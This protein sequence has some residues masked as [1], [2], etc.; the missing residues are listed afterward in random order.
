M[1]VLSTLSLVL[2]FS[3]LHAQTV[4]PDFTFIEG[5]IIG[6]ESIN[7]LRC[8]NVA[9]DCGPFVATEIYRSSLDLATG[10]LRP[11]ALLDRVTD[12]AATTYED[13]TDG[14][15]YFYFLRYD[16]DC[17][18]AMGPS[19]DTLRSGPLQPVDI[20][21]FSVEDG[22]LRIAYTAS[23]PQTTNYVISLTMGGTNEVIGTTGNELSYLIPFDVLAGLGVDPMGDVSGLFIV[24][25]TDEVC[26]NTSPQSQPRRPG[27]VLASGGEGCTNAISYDLSQSRVGELDAID[28]AGVELFISANGGPF[29]GQGVQPATSTELT[30]DG[31]NDGDEI[32]QYVEY[33]VAGTDERFRVIVLPGTQTIDI[34]QPV[35]DFAVFGVSELPNGQ[36]AVEVELLPN[37][38]TIVAAE[39]QVLTLSGQVNVL[40]VDPAIIAGSTAFPLPVFEPAPIAGEGLRFE[41]TDACG[42]TARTNEV[43]PVRLTASPAGPGINS[44]AWT[45]LINN[46]LGTTTYS[47]FR[48]DT[49]GGNTSVELLASNLTDLAY[50]DNTSGGG[51]VC[52]F[53]DATFTPAAAP[54]AANPPSYLFR[55]L[56]QCIVPRPV[57]YV[58][59]AF[60]PESPNDANATFRPFFADPP[61]FQRYQLTVFDRWGAV[62]FQTTDPD[63]G[64]DGMIA[65][66]RAPTGVYIYV[67]DYATSQNEESRS[68]AINLLR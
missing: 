27:V 64:W 15:T 18:T 10:N 5:E 67:L 34:T 26:G 65:S 55:S 7:T 62:A 41:V 38:G 35:R 30:F 32:R 56:P 24:E 12:P 25:A 66:Q 48:L 36:L 2:L 50:V 13:P 21:Y 43:E 16:Y 19:S 52:Y 28:L 59:N 46:L 20:R 6:S 45:P 47:V 42:R 11:F 39:L 22:G 54:G 40:D 63:E 51:E 1:K 44:L 57:V 29:V 37:Q 61:A 23:S 31:G 53:I 8:E 60:N 17:G 4:A 33:L 14:V 58:P 68:G 49:T 9:E 3:F